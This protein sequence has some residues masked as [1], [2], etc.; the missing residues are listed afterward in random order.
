[1]MATL[2][3]PV[4]RPYWSTVTCDTLALEPYRPAVTPLAGKTPVDKVPNETLL[5]LMFESPEALLALKSPCTVNPVNWPTLVILGWAACTTELAVATV[6]VM[7][8]AWIP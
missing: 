8:D 3:A 6:S 4:T 2:E 7:A 1:M 5:A